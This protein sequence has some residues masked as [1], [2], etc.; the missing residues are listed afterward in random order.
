MMMRR[1][2]PV[3][4]RPGTEAAAGAMGVRVVAR[5]AV[6]GQLRPRA[7]I[8]WSRVVGRICNPSAESRT[9]CKSVLRN[10]HNFFLRGPLATLHGKRR[11][12]GNRLL[13]GALAG[14][15]AEKAAEVRGRHIGELRLNHEQFART[16]AGQSRVG[17]LQVA[18]DL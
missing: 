16:E 10:L 4:D 5:P 17:G 7:T 15:G 13:E 6:P 9:D 11:G 12:L 18:A 1:A 2:C 3:K 8:T 14:A